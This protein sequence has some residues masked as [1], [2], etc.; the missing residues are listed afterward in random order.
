[1][2]LSI[3]LLSSGKMDSDIIIK[4]PIVSPQQLNR[5]LRYCSRIE[6]CRMFERCGLTLQQA[7]ELIPP[8][9]IHY[10]PMKERIQ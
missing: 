2:S 6:A 7:A 1:M 10:Q 9:W 8:T 3:S 4:I 5:Y